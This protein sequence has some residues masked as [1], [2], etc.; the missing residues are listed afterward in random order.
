MKIVGHWRSR[1][2]HLARGEV[3]RANAQITE[4]E[5]AERREADRLNERIALIPIDDSRFEE[6]TPDVSPLQP[7]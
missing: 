5:A 3:R 1:Y 6:T 4:E 2:Q 7:E